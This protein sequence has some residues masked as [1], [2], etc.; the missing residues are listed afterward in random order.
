MPEEQQA[1]SPQV[2]EVAAP[3]EENDGPAEEIQ[4]KEVGASK[5]DGSDQVEAEPAEAPEADDALDVG[6][7]DNKIKI[8]KGTPPEVADQ[9][10]A[11]SKELQSG[12]TQK[13]QK[14]ADE[15]RA[16]EAARAQVQA[17]MQMAMQ[18]VEEV[19]QLKTLDSQLEAYSKVD[20]QSYADQ[21][22]AAAQK[23]FMQFTQLQNQRSQIA[24]TLTAKQQQ[25]LAKQQAES[26]RLLAEGRATLAQKIQ[27][28]GEAKQQELAKHAQEAYGFKPQELAYVMD[29]RVVL[30]M[31]DAYAFRQAKQQAVAVKP[32][33]PPPEP[34]QKVGS[35][36]PVAKTPDKMSMSEWMD[37]RNR[38]VAR[39]SRR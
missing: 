1:I 11:I 10:R 26:E 13:T 17:Q 35:S 36:A 32:Q 20:W 28:W 27:G 21:D 25:A 14:I 23:H 31:N 4:F 22:P 18:S 15:G 2:E 39:K 12:F 6:F 7:V 30:M 19:A 29:P 9:I 37:W 24:Q 33:A 38:Q 34:V 3:V 8:P 16:L 5:H